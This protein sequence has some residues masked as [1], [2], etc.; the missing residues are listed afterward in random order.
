[1][2]EQLTIGEELKVRRARAGIKQA[3]L[4]QRSGIARDD[5]SAWESGRMYPGPEVELAVREALDWPG[6]PGR[7]VIGNGAG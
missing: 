5:I 4:A 2:V 6:G 3:E 1:M 7:F